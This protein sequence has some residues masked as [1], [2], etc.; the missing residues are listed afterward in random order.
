MNSKGDE[1]IIRKKLEIVDMNWISDNLFELLA[2]SYYSHTRAHLKP[3]ILS[4]D[5]VPSN[6]G[7]P[8]SWSTPWPLTSCSSNKNID[9]AGAINFRS[10]TVLEE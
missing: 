3:Y 10:R 8:C 7:P 9:S 4:L 2:H 5:L 1:I 6:L